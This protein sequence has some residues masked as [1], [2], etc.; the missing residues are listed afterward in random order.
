MQTTQTTR[1][2]RQRAAFSFLMK[3]ALDRLDRA[4]V[5]EVEPRLLE[6]A[7]ACEHLA[8]RRC[9]CEAHA[10]AGVFDGEEKCL[11]IILVRRARNRPIARA[12]ECDV[13]LDHI[14]RLRAQ[15]NEE[16]QL[17]LTLRVDRNLAWKEVAQ[18][19]A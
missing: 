19:L 9:R 1:A 11:P 5:P 6:P 18:I 12:I 17:L 14:A 4:V 3:P 13:R 10:I 15:L 2:A 16:E 7:I 8:K